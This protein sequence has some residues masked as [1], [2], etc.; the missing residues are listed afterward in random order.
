MIPYTII[1]EA[2]PDRVKGSATGAMN[3][4]TFSVTAVVGPIF[5]NHF[6]KTWGTAVDHA[7]HLRHTHLFW[8]SIVVLSLV[9]TMFLK[10]T[11]GGERGGNISPASV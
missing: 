2:N 11:G 4:L 10:E 7:A 3:F 6:A 8:I 1:K 5:S 9:L